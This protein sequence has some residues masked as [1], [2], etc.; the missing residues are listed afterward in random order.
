LTQGQF[1]PYEICQFQILTQ[2]WKYL[3][4][5]LESEDVDDTGREPS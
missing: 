3:L 2:H 4:Y 1:Y 5:R